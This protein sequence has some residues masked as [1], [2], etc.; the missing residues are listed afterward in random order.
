YQSIIGQSKK[1]GLSDE[2]IKNYESILKNVEVCQQYSTWP[3]DNRENFR[4]Q[5]EAL[6]L[7][8]DAQLNALNLQNEASLA[9]LQSDYQ[10]I[11]DQSQQSNLSDEEIQNYQSML[12]QIEVRQQYSALPSDNRGKYREQLE[13]LGLGTD[14]QLVVLNLQNEASLAA[15]QSDYQTII[16]QSQQ[17]N[18]SDKEIQNYQL[19]LNQIEV[20]QQYSALT[21]EHQERF[22]KKWEALE[23]GTIEQLNALYSQE[24]PSLEVLRSDYQTIIDQSEQSD[25]PKEEIQNY[26]SML[27]I[28]EAQIEYAKGIVKEDKGAYEDALSLYQTA[29][30]RGHIKAMSNLGLFYL[31]G[32]KGVV[33]KDEKKAVELITS[34]V[35][36]GHAR[37]Q[38]NLARMYEK[39]CGVEMDMDKAI[40]WY[41]KAADNG[42][43]SAEKKLKKLQ[44]I[45]KTNMPPAQLPQP[46]LS[47]L[48]T[49]RMFKKPPPE[50]TGF[51]E[52]ESQEA[53]PAPSRGPMK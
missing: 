6:G 23:L 35:E 44:A 7:G 40:E 9:A 26:R 1:S 53:E 29:V 20:R 11:I 5:L 22:R 32:K 28:V 2:Q 46:P 31:E 42:D 16:D 21:P 37:S 36:K 13:A 45:N 3:S 47:Q 14:A 48:V 30:Q 43:K 25:L 38:Y 50:G 33:A 39:G 10:I 34:A 17:S 18:L 41:Q 8:T 24:I 15:L 49:A 4:E 51:G 12:N 27:N 52:A 19:M